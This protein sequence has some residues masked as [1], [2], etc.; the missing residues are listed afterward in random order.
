VA[1]QPAS[2]RAHTFIPPPANAIVSMRRF[3]PVSP[4]W[5]TIF[6]QPDGHGLLTSRIGETGG[7]PHRPFQLSAHWPGGEGRSCLDA[8]AG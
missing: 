8:P 6:V 4:M 3:S 2:E 1:T 5:Q 7:A